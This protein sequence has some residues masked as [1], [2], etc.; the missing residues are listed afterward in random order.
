M[1]VGKLDA[2]GTISALGDDIWA[3][4][5]GIKRAGASLFG[6]HLTTNVARIDRATLRVSERRNLWSGPLG[7]PI[8]FRVVDINGAPY[9]AYL[10]ATTLLGEA[11]PTIEAASQP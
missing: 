7:L 2:Q 3:S 1:S 11:Q 9:A 10:R 8:P 6:Y 5:R 4:W